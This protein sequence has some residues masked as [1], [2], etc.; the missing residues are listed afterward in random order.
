M[1]H[2][3]RQSAKPKVEPDAVGMVYQTI[4]YILT[5]LA[6]EVDTL[7]C[8]W[9]GAVGVMACGCSPLADHWFDAA[10]HQHDT[11]QTAQACL[12]DVAPQLASV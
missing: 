7:A 8:Q 10:G 11:S 2:R 9:A 12:R 6:D 4:T 1:Q 5:R 3:R